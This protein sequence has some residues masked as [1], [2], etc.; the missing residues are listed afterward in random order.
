MRIFVS[1]KIGK[2]L[3]N[4]IIE[5]QKSRDDLKVRWLKP[6]N[7]HI[8]LIPPWETQNIE[9]VKNKLKS[10]PRGEQSELYGGEFD[11][12]FNKVSFGPKPEHPRLIW[13]EGKSPENFKKLR[14][15]SKH[16]R[17]MARKSRPFSTSH[18]VRRSASRRAPRNR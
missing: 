7:L 2:E 13:A 11:I 4:K 6:E 8:T 5:W 14:K 15:N 1:V 9:E 12:L 17:R 16:T 3:E 18:S 10:L